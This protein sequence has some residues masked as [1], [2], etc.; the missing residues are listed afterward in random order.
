MPKGPKLLQMRIESSP[1]YGAHGG[2]YT[3]C[4]RTEYLT[5][6]SPQF[7]NETSLTNFKK[8]YQIGEEEVNISLDG[9]RR[10]YADPSGAPESVSPHLPTPQIR[11]I[12]YHV[13]T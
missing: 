12:V 8:G 6:L 2:R 13:I 4:A 1:V 7:T 9:F 3:K 10:S 5:R 11:I